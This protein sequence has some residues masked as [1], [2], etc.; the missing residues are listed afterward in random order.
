VLLFLGK[1]LP[2]G[3]VVG[4]LLS[5]G[6]VCA[7]ADIDTEDVVLSPSGSDNNVTDGSVITVF[8]DEVHIDQFNSSLGTLISATLSWDAT[9]SLTVENNME[10]QGVMSYQTSSDPEGWNITTFG[11]TATVDFSISGSEALSL[12]GLTGTGKVDEGPFAETFQNQGGYF[13]DTFQTGATS[14][15]FTITYDY[16]PAGAPPPPPPP[17][18]PEMSSVSYL[19]TSVSLIGLFLFGRRRS[20]HTRAR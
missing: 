7:R 2:A 4:T 8:S 9:G 13:P 16:T 20:L 14:G 11:G 3:V 17:S 19:F 1:V 5:L 6:C 15:T 12:T 18:V 10:G